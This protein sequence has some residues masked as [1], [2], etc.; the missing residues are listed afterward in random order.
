MTHSS[1]FINWIST[2]HTSCSSV[3][4]SS[5]RRVHASRTRFPFV[6]NKKNVRSNFQPLASDWDGDRRGQ[7]SHRCGVLCFSKDIPCGQHHPT[8]SC[9]PIARTSPILLPY[10]LTGAISGYAFSYDLS[11]LLFSVLQINAIMSLNKPCVQYICMDFVVMLRDKKK[12]IV[13]TEHSYS[14]SENNVLYII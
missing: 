4:L 5:L 6:H 1:D 7:G 8:L 3:I 14:L 9:V 10:S 2:S 12:L 11:F 13:N